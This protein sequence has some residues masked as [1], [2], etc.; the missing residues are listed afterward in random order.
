MALSSSK[1]L[2]GLVLG[3]LIGIIGGFIYF[4]PSIQENADQIDDLEITITSLESAISSLEN[5]N[6]ALID[7]YN[8]LSEDYNAL[9]VE[10]STLI[11]DYNTLWDIYD[12]LE[13]EYEEIKYQYNMWTELRIGNSLTS[14]YD[15]L[16]YE[17]GPTGSR[18]NWKYEEESCQFASQLALHDLHRLYW[19]KAE[20]IY[21]ED[22]GKESYAQAWEVLSK[23]YEYCEISS[24]DSD[25]EKIEK[26]LVFV[27]SIIDFELE[28]DDSLRAPVETLSLKSGDCDDFS[29]LVSALFE[30][31]DIESGVCFLESEDSAHAMVLVHLEDLDE[32]G[33]YYYE[34]L[35][36]YNFEDGTWILIEPQSTIDYQ[37]DADWFDQ[38]SLYMAVEVDYEKA[39]S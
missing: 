3:V 17:F 23:A 11:N 31:A 18:S 37:D 25:V 2:V 14:Y 27:N 22:V 4:D 26:I 15:T 36:Q 1:I 39:T 24:T 5:E 21:G 32:Y 35:T 7:D 28:M 8:D 38:W 10:Y 30:I 12:E 19:I 6:D 34:D 20:E 16:R 9:S 33:C 13:S 29:V